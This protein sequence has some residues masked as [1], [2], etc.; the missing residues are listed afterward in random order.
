MDMCFV[1]LSASGK[2]TVA[3]FLQGKKIDLDINNENKNELNKIGI[4]KKITTSTTRKPRSNE[5][6]G[7]DYYFFDVKTFKKMIKEDYFLEY[8]N[9]F[10]NLYGTLKNE[11]NKECSQNRI[12]VMDPQGMT[13]IKNMNK[14][15][16][17][18]FFDVSLNTSFNRMNIRKD[19]REEIEKRMKEYEYFSKCKEICDFVVDAN[20]PINEVISEVLQIV[21]NVQK[22]ISIA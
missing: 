15:V 8:A 4:F 10:G 17:T 3:D 22:N 18:I 7:V 21:N 19:N 16:I 13:K 14:D 5:V 11:L 2:T 9:V 12:I 6:D 20:K 1:G